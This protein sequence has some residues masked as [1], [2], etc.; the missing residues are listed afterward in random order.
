MLIVLYFSALLASGPKLT[1]EV[2]PQL[3]D[4]AAVEKGAVV[5]AAQHLLP[6]IPRG[7]L[8]FDSLPRNGP[9]RSHAQSVAL[10]QILGAKATTRQSV[11]SCSSGPSSCRM[12]GYSGLVGVQLENMADSTAEVAVSVHWPSQ[13]RRVPISLHEQSLLFAK[14][15]GEWQF[16]RV[17]RARSN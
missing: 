4:T 5:Y 6:G 1:N 3:P 16:V 10:A 8:A 12:R 9:S 15:K 17:L 13:Q 14:R 11:I 7:R 2:R